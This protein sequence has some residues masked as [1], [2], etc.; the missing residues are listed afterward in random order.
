MKIDNV[1]TL[2]DGRKLAYAEFGNPDGHPVLYCH[3][4]PCSRL[5][6]L[7]LGGDALLWCGLLRFVSQRRGTAPGEEDVDAL[8]D[9]DGLGETEF[10]ADRGFAGLGRHIELFEHGFDGVEVLWRIRG[11][12]DRV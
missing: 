10:E 4:A 12:D 1:L 6:P 2:P 5:E 3:S 11:D 9:F 7:L 8:G